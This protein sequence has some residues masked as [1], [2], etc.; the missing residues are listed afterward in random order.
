V[1]SLRVLLRTRLE[2]IEEHLM[3]NAEKNGYGYITPSMA[4]LYSY[5]GNTPVPMSELA[6]RL[7]I[8]RQAV[9]QLVNEGINSGFLE[10]LDSPKDK[11]VKMVQFSQEGQKMA[12][13]AIAEI[14]KAE[15]ELKQYLGAENVQQLRRI[16]ELKWPDDS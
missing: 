10:L 9:H 13:V 8:S 5:L 11:R 4:R 7:K 15:E 3:Q 12:A 14:N 16:L 1:K 6:R 2:W